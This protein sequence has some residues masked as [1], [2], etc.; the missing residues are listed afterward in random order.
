MPNRFKIRQ[1][2]DNE[3]KMWNQEGVFFAEFRRHTAKLECFAGE[4]R[5]NFLK[6]TGTSPIENSLVV[7]STMV[8]KLLDEWCDRIELEEH[9]KESSISAVLELMD[10]N[11]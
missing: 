9:L 8:K 2:Y 3:K 1:A 11:P 10:G 6:S 7:P 4:V 5:I